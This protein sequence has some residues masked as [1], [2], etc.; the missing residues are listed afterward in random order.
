MI[1]IR[2]AS[3]AKRDLAETVLWYAEAGAKLDRR[4]EADL[5][6]TL[7]QVQ[8]HPQLYPRIEGEIR[9]APFRKFP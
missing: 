6:R 9:R 1:P 3:I 8:V 7:R 5:D 4:F 2:F